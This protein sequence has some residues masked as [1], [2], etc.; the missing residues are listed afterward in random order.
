MTALF[1]PSLLRPNYN[2]S[3]IVIYLLPIFF[4]LSPIFFQ[5]LRALLQIFHRTNSDLFYGQTK[6]CAR[7]QIGQGGTRVVLHCAK[8]LQITIL[9]VPN[10]SFIQGLTSR[11]GVLRGCPE[12]S[13]SKK[14]HFQTSIPPHLIKSHH[15]RNLPPS[16]P[17][18]L[19]TSHFES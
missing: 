2:L 11:S 16:P 17:H 5:S 12:M 7:V 3:P 9:R 18:H 1:W 8:K 14:G 19:I 10:Y 15:F 4:N 13:S 6:I